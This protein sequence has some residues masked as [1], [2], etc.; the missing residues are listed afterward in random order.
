VRLEG[1]EVQEGRKI[2]AES[3]L[4]IISAEGLTDAAKK[5]VAAAGK[6]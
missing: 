4:N 1:T 3:K 6:A 5:V 2:L